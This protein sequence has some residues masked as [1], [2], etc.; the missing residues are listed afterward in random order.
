MTVI[1]LCID[2]DNDL[3]R[4]AGLQ[5]PLIGREENLEAAMKFA[6]ADPEDSDLNALFYAV[7]IFDEL[8]IKDKEIITLTGH[9][10]KGF[11][12]DSI[13]SKKLD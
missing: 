13:I 8:K 3:G 1:V 7:K 5:T 6:L 12:S 9:D 11:Q 4:K 2:Y 10:T